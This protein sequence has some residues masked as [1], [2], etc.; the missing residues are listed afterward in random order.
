MEAAL[1]RS[2]VLPVLAAIAALS[3]AVSPKARAAL[4][5]ALASERRP[6]MRSALELALAESKR[7]HAGLGLHR[8]PSSEDLA[9]TQNPLREAA[10]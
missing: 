6:H 8:A 9:Q 10:L 7:R 1:R 2:F 3:T 4:E 5:W